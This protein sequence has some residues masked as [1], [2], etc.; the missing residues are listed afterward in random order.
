MSLF[1]LKDII[2]KLIFTKIT[3]E[4]IQEEYARVFIANWVDLPAGQ[5]VTTVC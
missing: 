5:L 4:N 1:L 3:D 2:L